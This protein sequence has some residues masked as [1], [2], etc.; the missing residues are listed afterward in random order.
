MLSLMKALPRTAM[1]ADS[2]GMGQAIHFSAN[3]RSTSIASKGPILNLVSWIALAMLCIAVLTAMTSKVA[4]EHK[5]IRS[6]LILTLVCPLGG[7]GKASPH[8]RIDVHGGLHRFDQ[9]PSTLC[10]GLSASDAEQA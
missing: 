6:L 1:V 4:T 3:V 9:S 8:K 5:L 2:L 7:G 10:L